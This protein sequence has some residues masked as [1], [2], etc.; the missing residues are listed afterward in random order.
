[1]NGFDIAFSG[2]LGCAYY[3]PTKCIIYVMEDTLDKPPYDLMHMCKSPLP[4]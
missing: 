2:K 3:D 4:S 1:M